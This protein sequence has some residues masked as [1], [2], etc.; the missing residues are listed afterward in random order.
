MAMIKY[1]LYKKNNSRKNTLLY[2]GLGSVSL[3]R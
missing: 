3:D 1:P 2:P